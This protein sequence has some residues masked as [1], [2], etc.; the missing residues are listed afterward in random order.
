MSTFQLLRAELWH[1]KTNFLLSLLAIVT[2]AALF[3]ASPTLLRGYARE[4]EQ[5]LA[6]MQAETDAQLAAM[7]KKAADDL[8]NLDKRTKR[9]MRDLGFNL[10]IVHQNTNLTQLY[11]NFVSLDMPEEY[12]QRLAESPQITKIAHLVA[13]LKQMV[14][15]DEEPRLLVGFAPEAVQ[16]HVEKKPPM[17]FNIKPGT[18]YLGHLAG[19][20]RDVGQQIDVLGQSFEIA[21]ILP[22]QG[23]RDQD[24][25]ICMHLA[26]AQQVLNKPGKITEIV[27]LGCKCETIDRVEEITAQLKLVLPEAQ[28]I[29]LTDIAVGRENQRLLVVAHNRQTMD[30]YAAGRQ[31]IID[32]EKEHQAQVM[33]V[34]GAAANFVTPLVVLACAVWVGLL[35]WMN[36]RERR[37]EIGL[38][39]A[40]GR[41]TSNIVS[42]LLGKAAL[43]GL[44]GGLV[45]CAVGYLLARQAGGAVLEVGVENFIPAL[46]ILVATLLGAPLVALLASYLPTLSAVMQDPAV[47]LLEE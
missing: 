13:T 28:V 41:R 31:T 10:R 42:L 22:P 38:L 1:R 11:A 7:E 40:L 6:A 18:V 2:A 3:V 29:E 37:T 9:I 14:E 43:I 34:I 36:V 32:K 23:T 4:S 39:R 45:G 27:A 21:R 17:G 19:E 5:R 25:A 44:L 30:D 24:I 33:H 26:D 8:A 16:T 20:G 12:V 35:A 15:I 47:V 46:D